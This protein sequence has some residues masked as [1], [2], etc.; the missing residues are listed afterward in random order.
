M[1][2]FLMFIMVGL[3]LGASAAHAAGEK[4]LPRCYMDITAD[5]KPVGRIVV[6]LRA[7]V[8]PKTAENFRAC[9]PAKRDS[10]TRAARSIV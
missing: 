8:V 7:D 9:A 1:F 3:A 10:A 4:P 5:G 2:Q 6:E